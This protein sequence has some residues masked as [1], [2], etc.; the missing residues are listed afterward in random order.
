MTSRDL[1]IA[2]AVGA[3]VGQTTAFVLNAIRRAVNN[4]RLDRARVCRVC[5]GERLIPSAVEVENADGSRGLLPVD[6]PCPVCN[7]RGKHGR[8]KAS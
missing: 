3:A 8:P 7:P 2:A 5:R 1:L 6:F 4:W